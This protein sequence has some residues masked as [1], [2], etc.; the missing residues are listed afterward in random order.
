VLKII[1]ERVCV[2][3]NIVVQTLLEKQL[4]S[5]FRLSDGFL[6]H[7]FLS[8]LEDAALLPFPICQNENIMFLKR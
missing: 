1:V 7:F 3:R 2:C 5:G 8:S 4:Q 6:L